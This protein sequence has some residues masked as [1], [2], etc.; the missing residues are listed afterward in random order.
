M[1]APAAASR[2]RLDSAPRAPI[3]TQRASGSIRLLQCGQSFR[4]FGASWSHQLQNLRFSTAQG[5]SETVG[6]SGSSSPTTSS[7]SP[8]SRS[9]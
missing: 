9:T 7:S 5:S 8:V 6:A 1:Q 4:S 3:I 2:L